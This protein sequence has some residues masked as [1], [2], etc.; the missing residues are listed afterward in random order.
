MNTKIDTHKV[1]ADYFKPYGKHLQAAAYYVSAKLSDGHICFSIDEYNQKISEEEIELNPFLKENELLDINKLQVECVVTS[2][3]LSLG[4]VQP[5]VLI[6]DDRFYLQRYFQ[7]ESNLLSRL[8]KFISNENSSIAARKNELIVQ[9]GF[10]QDLFE[11]D[12]SGPNWQKV[13]ALTSFIYNFS[14]ITGGPGTGKTT[15]VAKLLALLYTV[16][17]DLKVALA[18][19]TGKAAARMNESLQNSKNSLDSISDNIKSKYEDISAGTIHRLLGA[20]KNSPYFKHDKDNLLHYD[21]IIV[22][23]SSMIDITLM[24]KLLDPIPSSSRVIFLGDKEQLASVEAGSVFGDLCLSQK[25]TINHF[26][27][28]SLSYLNQFS[29]QQKKL[30]DQYILSNPNNDLAEHVVELQHSFRF[31]STEGIG[32]FSYQVINGTLENLD[33]FKNF[34]QKGEHVVI[35]DQYKDEHL[36][37]VLE[38]YIDYIN[39]PNVKI[40]LQKLNS[41]RVLCAV[42]QGNFGVDDYNS[43]CENYLR[44]KSSLRPR[45]GYYHNQPIMVTKNNN[46]L[47]LYNGD[48]G[49]IRKD[50]DGNLKAYFEDV[51][52]GIREVLPGYITSY[53]TVFAMTIHKSQ[54]SEF[55]NVVVVL[56]DDEDLPLL[57][58]ELLYTG[59]TRAKKKVLVL[60]KDNVVIKASQ[61][62]VT[63]ASGVIERLS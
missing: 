8:Q 24:S 49:I 55:Q 30:N 60:A 16:Q 21:V 38:N 37:N 48:V 18:A 14:I 12:I 43:Y 40:A 17:P 10:I 26:Y 35:H 19:P 61:R 2:E 11:S 59:I 29:S 22:D 36:N 9:K 15:T 47:K 4:D 57:T 41:I 63:R 56:P 13:A 7:Y 44:S 33:T 20:I 52:E 54:G 46:S 42:R 62:K 51:E 5:F 45:Q 31:K 27:E 23:E 53:T 6:N 3:G 25:D 1:F 58:R 32:K 28:S 50:H 34:E 39:E